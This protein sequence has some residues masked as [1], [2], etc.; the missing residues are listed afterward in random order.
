MKVYVYHTACQ[1]RAMDSYKFKKYF[2]LNNHK[3][4]NSPDKADL[5]IYVACAVLNKETEHALEQVKKFQKYDAELIVGGCLPGIDKD[6]LEEVFDGKYLSTKD[7]EKIDEFFPENKIKFSEIDDVNCLYENVNSSNIRDNLRIVKKK[8]KFLDKI[9]FTYKISIIKAI[10]GEH[11]IPHRAFEKYHYIRI[12]WG[13]MN[14]CAYCGIRKAIGPM[15]SKP[16][17]ECIREFK[18]GFE[19]GHKNFFIS[20][21]DIGSYGMDINSSFPELL[22]KF[23][24]T[25]GDYTITIQNLDPRYVVR[26]IDELEEIT[27]TKKIV[28]MGIAVQ[29]GS[30]RILK[31]MNRYPKVDEIID[32]LLRL[33]K[34]NPKL[35]IP[36]AFII[37]FPT[38]TY[39]DFQKT[40]DF[41]NKVKF[42]SGFMFRFSLKPGTIAENIEPKVPKKEAIKRFDESE[43]FMRDY[44]YKIKK[45]SKQASYIFFKK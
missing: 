24:E 14:R 9:Y 45:I 25:R 31:L 7:I 23:L 1:R 10:Y 17:D 6:K 22:N 26:Y 43:G 12:S 29:S 27:R 20:A 40:L 13:C 11:S 42:R 37:G 33:K 15:Y 38:E 16:L 28:N 44:N 18:K 41:I 35:V 3:I 19:L 36:T 4:V 32:C 39:Q 21:D 8:I 34:A 2:L 30:S 5:I